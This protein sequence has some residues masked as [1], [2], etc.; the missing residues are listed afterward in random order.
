M[1][2]NDDLGASVTSEEQNQARPVLPPRPSTLSLMPNSNAASASR[3][4]L[5]AGLISL[6]TTAVSKSDVSAVSRVGSLQDLSIHSH[7]DVSSPSISKAASRTASEAADDS[8]V[9]STEFSSDPGAERES[10]FGDG[11][12]QRLS[13]TFESGS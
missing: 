13:G 12:G 1:N 7:R 5:R 6:A 11:I 10:L 8:S 2:T 4:A 3:P 9:K